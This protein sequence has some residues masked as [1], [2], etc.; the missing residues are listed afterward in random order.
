M[1]SFKDFELAEGKTLTVKNVKTGIKITNKAHP[2]WGVFVVKNMSDNVW[3]LEGDSKL[4]MVHNDNKQ[5][6]DWMLESLD[7]AGNV[8]YA[9]IRKGSSQG[10]T[11]GLKVI[12]GVADI[13][14]IKGQPGPIEK[15]FTFDSS[16]LA[17]A[18]VK[19]YGTKA[20]DYLVAPL[21]GGNFAGII[22]KRTD[23]K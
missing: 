7:E 10:D 12:K 1:K 16:K 11:R 6:K 23:S 4:R 3:D 22:V 14:K 8:Q 13:R 15:K 5:L 21:V 2:D 19:E 20:S 18:Y 9:V 17:W